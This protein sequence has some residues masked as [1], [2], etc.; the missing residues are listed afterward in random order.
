MAPEGDEDRRAEAAFA[1]LS[2][3]ACPPLGEVLFAVTAAWRPANWSEL[4]AQLDQ[5]ARPLFAAGPSGRERAGLLLDT[6]RDEARAVDG[7]WLD[8]VLA[9]R[10]GHPVLIAAV[11]TELGRRAGWDITVCSSPTAWYAGLHDA[12]VLWLID[13]TG[14]TSGSRAPRTVR[15]HCAHEIAFVVLTGLAERF[16][17]THDQAQARSLRERLALFAAP[18]HP[19]PALLGALW[20]EDD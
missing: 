1:A 3:R 5:L 17:R 6:F 20:T 10:R 18:E 2:R 12:G 8:E 13:P 4:D 9:G 14:E 16:A 11:A 7:L 15:R 19:G